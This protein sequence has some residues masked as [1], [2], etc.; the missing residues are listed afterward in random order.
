MPEDDLQSEWV[1]LLD[2]EGIE[3][4]MV[5]SDADLEA[6]TSET[7][8]QVVFVDFATLTSSD[9]KECIERCSQLKL[10]VIFWRRRSIH[11]SQSQ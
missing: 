4:A 11:R 9:V 3:F 7:P 1:E 8:P 10:P 5:K 6:I 2:E